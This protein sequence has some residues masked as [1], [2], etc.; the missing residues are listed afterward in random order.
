LLPEEKAEKKGTK[1]EE[2]SR[3]N[4]ILAVIMDVFL[5]SARFI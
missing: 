3:E 2:L 5:C 4:E 1:V